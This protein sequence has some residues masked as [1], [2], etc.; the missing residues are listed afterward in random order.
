[1]VMESLD[2]LSDWIIGRMVMGSLAGLVMSPLVGLMMGSMV[3]MVMG[4]LVDIKLA[5]GSIGKFGDGANE[6]IS[7]RT[8][9]PIS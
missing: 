3:E 4:S 1:M 8:N 6:H 9:E 7:N 2:G 5:I